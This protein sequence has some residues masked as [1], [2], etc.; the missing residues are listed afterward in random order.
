MIT[1]AWK[2]VPRDNDPAKAFDLINSEWVMLPDRNAAIKLDPRIMGPMCGDYLSVPIAYAAN[3]CQDSHLQNIGAVNWEMF[4][5]HVAIPMV[6][7]NLAHTM[8]SLN[9]PVQEVGHYLVAQGLTQDEAMAVF[10]RPEE[11][12]D[13][14]S[15]HKFL[16]EPHIF[17]AQAN[18]EVRP[19]IALDPVFLVKAQKHPVE[20]IASVIYV[21]SQ[22]RDLATK[23]TFTDSKQDLHLRAR[24]YQA[25]FLLEAEAANPGYTLEDFYIKILNEYPQGTQTDVPERRLLY[26]S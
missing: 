8:L 10:Q 25:Q 17:I 20:T 23:R 1:E 18:D 21:A 22:V 4:S 15:R 5:R 19:I 16:G 13:L 14:M 6:N 12:D 9:I 2:Y 26:A 11:Y 3:H 7:S 24:M